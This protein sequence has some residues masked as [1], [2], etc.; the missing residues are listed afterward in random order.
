MAIMSCF[1]NSAERFPVVQ[2]VLRVIG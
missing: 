1:P 2:S